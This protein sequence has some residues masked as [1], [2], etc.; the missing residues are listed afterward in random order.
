MV[1]DHQNDILAAT[2]ASVPAV[3]AK[4][5]YGDDATGL[6]RRPPGSRHCRRW[7][8]GLFGDE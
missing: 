3:F 1:G 2:G 6:P 4:W 7:C 5:G 8:A